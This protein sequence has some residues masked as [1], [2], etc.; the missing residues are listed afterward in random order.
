MTSRMLALAAL[1]ALAF[2]STT[3]MSQP[4]QAMPAFAD[5]RKKGR[6][7]GFP[8]PRFVSQKAATARMRVGPSTDYATSWVYS[9]RGLPLEITEEYGNWRRVRDQDGVTGWMYAPLLSGHR[10]AVVGPWLDKTVELRAAPSATS[11]V[12]AR[13]SPRVLLEL[14]H[15]NGKWCEVSLTKRRMNGFVAQDNLWGVYPGELIE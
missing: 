6:E 2:L 13:L 10:T 8:I 4:L 14:D 12:V 3:P 5:G 1:A 15:C 9:V 11:R 7:T